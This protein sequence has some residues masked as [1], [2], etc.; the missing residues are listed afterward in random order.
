MFTKRVS[1]L[2]VASLAVALLPIGTAEARRILV[3][4]DPGAFE[5]NG[6]GWIFDT[7]QLYNQAAVDAGANRSM[8]FNFSGSYDPDNDGTTDNDVNFAFDQAS[9][10]RVGGS[11]Y[12]FVCMFANFSFSFSQSSGCDAAGDPIFSMLPI[13]GLSVVESTNPPDAGTVFSTLGFSVGIP[14]EGEPEFTE[15]YDIDT[16][17][18]T[19]RLWWN[20][21]AESYDF[22]N[23][24]GPTY[25]VQAFIYFLENG[26][27]DLDIR[28]GI[29]GATGFPAVERSINIDG[30]I[31]FASTVPAVA[32]DDYFYRFRGG[33]LQ[34]GATPPPT[35]VPEP[36]TLALLLA[37]LAVL[38]V[39]RRSP[40]FG[41]RRPQA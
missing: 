18:P 6:G 20:K 1:G 13:D 17:V 28:Y 10:L 30:Q 41:S 3:D 31:L 27:F 12:S 33:V 36:G 35:N 2:L 40:V 8:L 4:F 39:M 38:A 14:A 11:D 19:M 5:D 15:P 29:E 22:G 25:S 9:A 34:G 26:D 32:E 21:L 7:I 23:P 16:A 37:G 24:V